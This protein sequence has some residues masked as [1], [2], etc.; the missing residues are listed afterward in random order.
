MYKMLDNTAD[1]KIIII[2]TQ[3]NIKHRNLINI[4]KL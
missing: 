1:K 4:V 2:F 3:G